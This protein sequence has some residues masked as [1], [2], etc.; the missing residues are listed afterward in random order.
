M[1]HRT[2]RFLDQSLLVMAA[3]AFF[4]ML[5]VTTLSIVGRYL[6]SA[7]IPDDVVINEL[8]MVFVVFLPMAYA[9]RLKQ[10]FFVTLLSDRL[11]RKGSL[12]LE[13][14][15]NFV[16]F[17]LLCLL[18]YASWQSFMD[19]FSMRAFNAGVL[20]L[21]EY[22]SKFMLFLGVALMT[23]RLAL[24]VVTGLQGRMPGDGPL[25]HEDDH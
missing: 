15:G 1:I 19:S 16:G 21:P 23:L 3:I 25:M 8:L 11:S 12:A 24:D 14:L 4:V 20:Q 7:P 10:H 17:L 18:S 6:L 5:S 9:Q 22:P 2:L 13:T